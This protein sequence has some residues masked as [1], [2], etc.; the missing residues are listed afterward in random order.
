MNFDFWFAAAFRSV[1]YAILFIVWV[2]KGFL[3]VVAAAS[4]RRR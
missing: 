2:I 3:Y 1:W 4:N